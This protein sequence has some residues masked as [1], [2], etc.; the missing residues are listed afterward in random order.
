MYNPSTPLADYKGGLY[1]VMNERVRLRLEVYQS[2]YDIIGLQRLLLSKKIC[3]PICVFRF[4]SFKEFWILWRSTF[5]GKEFEYP[6]FLSATLLKHHFCMNDIKKNRIP[7]V[8]YIPQ[9]TYGTYIP[10][11]NPDRPEFEI[12][13]PY[14][15]KIRR[16][17]WNKYE[18]MSNR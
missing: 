9:G 6:A 14:R 4:V 1:G 11:V 3:E 18:I 7:I 17:S 5:F 12:L 16:L 15:L 13:L 10:E 8:I 2:D